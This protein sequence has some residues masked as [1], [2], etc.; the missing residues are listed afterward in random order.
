VLGVVEFGIEF[1]PRDPYWKIT[2]YA[3]QAEKTGFD[4]LWITDHFNNR[5]VYVSLAIVSA[6]TNRIKFGPGVTN[7]YLAH[8]VV[9]AQAV[10]T[11]NE[12]AP[13]RVVCGL[14]VGDKTTLQMVNIEQ[15]KPLATIRESVRI[16]REIA[17]GRTLEMQGEIFKAS[18]AK[19]TFK[20]ANPVP[21]FIGAQGP[22]M[23]ALAAEIG[24]GVLINASHEKD[25]ENAVKSVR[26]GAD[27][28]G[29][30]LEDLSISA[31]T[32]FSIASSPDKALKAVVPVVAYI[33]AGAP[34]MIL[35]QHGISVELASK[36]RD[37]I[38]HAQWKEAF[39]YVDNNMVEA[40]SICGTPG[41][42]IEKIS[43]LVKVGVNQIVV[44]SPIGPN[45]RQ[46][47]NTIATEVFPHFRK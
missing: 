28:A 33:V 29:K 5:N 4:C 44:G 23:L 15:S 46:S 22:K 34:E 41:T 2:F 24:D 31:Y 17:S 30:K 3:I 12:V 43:K 39:S 35:E 7:P 20:V 42:C 10:A 32:S 13:G 45:M 27:R 40:F 6:Y 38:V 36:I 37:A 21:V 25:V 8:P 16:I 26:E 18:G 47:I 14:G 11:L 19:L 1:V 9:T